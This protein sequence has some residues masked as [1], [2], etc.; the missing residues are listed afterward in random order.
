MNLPDVADAG[1]G[2]DEGR[3]M[4]VDSAGRGSTATISLS[5]TITR[6]PMGSSSWAP[7]SIRPNGSVRRLDPAGTK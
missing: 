4:S 7:A 2:V 1:V 3:A 5:S 6:L